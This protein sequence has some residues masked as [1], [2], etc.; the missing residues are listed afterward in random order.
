MNGQR[1]EAKCFE[2]MVSPVDV[3]LLMGN[4]IFLLRLVK[5][6]RKIDLRPEEA[7]YKR[8]VNIICNIDPLMEG[9]TNTNSLS[10]FP[11][12]DRACSHHG[13]HTKE[14]YK[15]QVNLGIETSGNLS[16]RLIGRC[17]LSGNTRILFT[18]SKREE[19]S[20]T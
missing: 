13:R 8:R 10:K 3:V 17:V 20:H 18:P 7:H 12:G 16:E 15:G 2:D 4:N 14:P 11:I 1:Q 6:T 5:R 9:N 19:R